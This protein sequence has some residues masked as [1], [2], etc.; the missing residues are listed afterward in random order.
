[1]A[2]ATD[3]FVELEDRERRV[4]PRLLRG[5]KRELW[6]QFVKRY[7]TGKY[8]GLSMTELFEWAK[9]YC[10]LRCSPSCF[11]QELHNQAG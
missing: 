4:T 8:D 2:K 9:K 3:P 5:K 6:T 10:G 7:R 11:R 1:M